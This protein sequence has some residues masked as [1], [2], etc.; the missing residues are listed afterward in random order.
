MANILFQTHKKRVNLV[1]FAFLSI[2]L[3]KIQMMQSNE[4]QKL[5]LN[6]FGS[7]KFNEHAAK[8]EGGEN[9][10]FIKYDFRNITKS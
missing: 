7:L 3:S 9:V 5:T 10:C 2:S 8:E 1:L 6:E 4:R